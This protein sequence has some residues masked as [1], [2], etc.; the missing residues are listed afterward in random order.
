MAAARL[1]NDPRFLAPSELR[2]RAN[3]IRRQKIVRRQYFAIITVVTIILFTA[4]FFGFSLL[5]DAQSEEFVPSYKYY[6]TVTVHAGDTLTGIANSYYCSDK[7]KNIE[8]YI[9][10]IEDINQLYDTSSILAGEQLIIPYYS[11]EYK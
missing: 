6:K 11:T 10:E 2:I 9:S 1:Y 5:S 7:Y 3:K 8:Q 4:I